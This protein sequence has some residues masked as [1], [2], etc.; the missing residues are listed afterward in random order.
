MA[1]ATD[2]NSTTGELDQ[3]AAFLTRLAMLPED[4][5]RQ[6]AAKIQ[7]WLRAYKEAATV[8][9]DEDGRPI[10]TAK[11]FAMHVEADIQ[12]VD[13][14]VQALIEMSMAA[15]DMISRRAVFTIAETLEKHVRALQLA[16][17]CA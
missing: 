7:N 11:G 15:D 12:A 16:M 10:T 3:W 5:Q 4:E 1:Q 8:L 9:V 2:S 17:R 6:E 13:G 14:L